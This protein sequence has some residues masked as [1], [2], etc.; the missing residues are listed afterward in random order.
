MKHVS[1]R[2]RIIITCN[3]TKFGC[4]NNL[5]SKIYAHFPEQVLHVTQ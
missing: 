1:H 4:Y 5:P 2:G 3:H